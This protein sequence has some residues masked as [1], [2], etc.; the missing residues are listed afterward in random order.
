MSREICIGMMYERCAKVWRVTG[1]RINH[2]KIIAGADD[3]DVEHVDIQKFLFESSEGLIQRL[4]PDGQGA[5]RPVPH[6]WRLREREKSKN[7]RLKREAI[8]MAEADETKARKSL[9]QAAEAIAA[10]CAERHWKTPTERTVR[11]WRKRARQ[12]ESLLSPQWDR[13]GN[14]LQGADELLLQAMENVFEATMAVNDRF[15][16]SAAWKLVE[17]KYDDLCAKKGQQPARHGIKKL[18]HYL[19]QM[20]WSDLMLAQLDLRTA[21]AITRRTKGLNTA[22]LF[23][24]VVEM[25]A[26]FLPILVRNEAGNPIGRPILYAAIDVASGYPVGLHLTIL[27]PSVPPFVEF[28][29]YM[30]F[31]KPEGFDEKYG[32]RKRIEVFGKPV[33]ARM[34]NGSEFIGETATA[35]VVHVLGDNAR[36]KPMTPQEKPHVER[37]NGS[38]KQF[39]RT[40]PG[41]TESAVT[42]GMRIVPATEDLLTIEELRGR[43][44]REIYDSYVFQ[45]NVLRSWKNRKTV[46]PYDIWMDMS[47]SHLPPFPVSRQEFELATYY[48]RAERTLNHDGIAFDG[49]TYHSVA[50]G[51]LYAATGSGKYEIRYSD[52]EAATILVLPRDGGEPVV[53]IA[54]ELQGLKVDRAT[55]AEIRAEFAADGKVLDRRS[56]PQ[57]LA[58]LEEQRKSAA[59]SMRGRNKQARKDEMM[60]MARDAIQPTMP[61]PDSASCGS[62]PAS[63]PAGGWDF[64]AGSQLGRN[65]GGQ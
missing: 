26:T 13:C 43:L 22:D 53:A 52:F 28:L 2:G 19:L 1:L 58:E 40:L 62:A 39:V 18:K 24:D 14:H 21:R 38:I 31:P 30:Y 4:V 41:S 47:R 55:A 36:C 60:K 54:K 32:I 63:N 61:P 15:T 44:Y 8:L 20:H 16:I 57:R 29:R 10:L 50:L 56:F 51:A 46:A 33:L 37:F 27:K 5:L 11:N 59:K 35:V 3:G 17:A 12:H 65:R 49:L 6:E 42:P 34:D 48:L 23:W 7:E 64:V 45:T 25:D 9:K